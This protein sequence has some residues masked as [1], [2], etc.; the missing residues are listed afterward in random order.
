MIRT[1]TTEL[2]PEFFSEKLLSINYCNERDAV[3]IGAYI[4]HTNFPLLY[5]V[6]S[7]F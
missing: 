4:T 6:L 3:K 5:I 7:E 1:L 2:I